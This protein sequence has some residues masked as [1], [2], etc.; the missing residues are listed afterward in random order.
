LGWGAPRGKKNKKKTFARQTSKKK[1]NFVFF[2]FIKCFFFSKP[3][4]GEK[5]TFACSG[6]GGGFSGDGA[7]FRGNGNLTPAQKKPPPS[8]GPRPKILNDFFFFPRA[9]KMDGGLFPIFSRGGAKA[10]GGG[11]WGKI[12]FS[13]NREKKTRPGSKFFFFIFFFFHWG[14]PGKKE[15]LLGRYR[16]GGAGLFGGGKKKKVLAKN[17]GKKVQFF[18]SIFKKP[19]KNCGTPPGP[20][21]GQKGGGW[22][23]GKI[24]PRGPPPGF[25][26]A[27]FFHPVPESLGAHGVFFSRGFFL[28]FPP[29]IIQKKPQKTFFFRGKGGF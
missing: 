14:K 9:V 5:R 4:Q 19:P 16:G 11:F 26:P 25:F 10:H 23:P 8:R 1:N 24:N 13:L 6:E 22:G 27:I 15:I 21:G 7:P 17:R 12:P 29:R 2:F 20:R 28:D 3:P 18:L